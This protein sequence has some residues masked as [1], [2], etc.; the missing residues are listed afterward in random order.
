MIRSARSGSLSPTTAMDGGYP[1]EVTGRDPW[2]IDADLFVIGPEQL[3]VQG[4]ADRLR[5]EGRLVFGPGSDGATLEGS[6]KF[7][8]ELLAEANVPSPRYGAFD[9]LAPAVEFLRSLEGPWVVKTDGLAAGKGVLVTGDIAEAEEDA[10]SKISGA[11]FGD[12]GRSIV[13]E[14]GLS[15]T[16]CSLM[17]VTDGLRLAPLAPAQDSKRLED[18]DCG[19]NTGGM[20][21]FS[22]VPVVDDRIID[23]V[24]DESVEPTLAALRRRGIDYRGI[25]YAGLMLTEDGPKVLEF[26]VRFGDPETQVVLPRID[27]DLTGL[28]AE[29]ASGRL[30]TDPKSSA[31]A[32]VCVVLA[33]YGYPRAPRTG[34]VI[35][36]LADA[37]GVPGVTVLHAGTALDANEGFV[38]AGG[39]V[40]DV[41]GTGTTIEY[42]RSSA[43]AA[44]SRISWEGE[45]HRTDI[46]A[47]VVTEVEE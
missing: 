2:N 23:R 35:E 10:A 18:G 43:Y 12:A 30:R 36:G 28:L 16:E 41:V 6:K 19:A 39:R 13:V 27:D 24:L 34:D 21:S 5:A 37:A 3:L 25:L 26:N 33:A 11:S 42:A 32:A 46:A 29:A 38:T 31:D 8:R 17:V 7:M 40:L 15:G 22:P 9:E 1:I 47:G 44:T 45:Q 14:E 20:G 4:L